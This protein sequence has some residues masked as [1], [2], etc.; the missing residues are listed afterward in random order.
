[1]LASVRATGWRFFCDMTYLN[2]SL[3]FV[4]LLVPLKKM[5]SVL[6]CSLQKLSGRTTFKHQ[7]PGSRG[8][9][10]PLLALLKKAE[11]N[12]QHP[13]HVSSSPRSVR[14]Q[15]LVGSWEASLIAI[16]TCL[17]A[18][19][20][21]IWSKYRLHLSIGQISTTV[22]AQWDYSRWWWEYSSQAWGWGLVS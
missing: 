9:C 13:G 11:W 14:R 17:F 3:V 6:F 1:M 8:V 18:A 22:Q 5:F 10:H 2:L 19:L 16:F 4:F 21:A 12:G 15:G 20:L 7:H